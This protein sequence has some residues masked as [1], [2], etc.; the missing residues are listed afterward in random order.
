MRRSTNRRVSLRTVLV[1]ML[2]CSGLAIGTS[3]ASAASAGATSDC[4]RDVLGDWFPDGRID[5]IYPLP[6]YEQAVKHLPPD[7]KQY[8][9]AR[10][11]I[12]RALQ[13]ALREKR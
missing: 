11:D 8:S 3:T 4:W 2:L 13:Q 6:C 1:L 10:D 12:Q 7:A 9:G 5:K